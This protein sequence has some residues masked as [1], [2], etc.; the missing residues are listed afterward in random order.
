MKEMGDGILLTLKELG[1][2]GSFCSIAA[3]FCEIAIRETEETNMQDKE[4]KIQILND[5]KERL[6][7]AKEYNVLF[8][9]FY[10]SKMGF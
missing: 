8:H 10:R 2:I 3:S 7:R 4:H 9:D 6:K 1:D 5:W